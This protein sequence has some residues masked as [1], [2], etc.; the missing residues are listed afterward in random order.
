MLVEETTNINPVLSL[1]TTLKGIIMKSL[2]SLALAFGMFLSALTASA[3]NAPDK[4]VEVLN[5]GPDQF[6]AEVTIPKNI[7]P[8]KEYKF[9]VQLKDMNNEPYALPAEF[10]KAKIDMVGMNMGSPTP[11]VT[12]VI[13]PTTKDNK[14]KLIIENL[15][16]SMSGPWYIS[17]YATYTSTEGNLVDEE[18]QSIN[19]TVR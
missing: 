3:Q 17:L 16:F 7:S 2:S 19:L 10:L 15:F 13:D 6:V 9:E 18:P 14:G 5:F 12:E 4:K 8:R 11:K 1:I